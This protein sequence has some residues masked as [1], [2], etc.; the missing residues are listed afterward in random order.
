[1]RYFFGQKN[2]QLNVTI[3]QAWYAHRKVCQFCKQEDPNLID[4]E[5]EKHKCLSCGGVWFVQK[6]TSDDLK[7]FVFLNS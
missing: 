6:P 2:L 4:V 7:K 5:Q 3:E 1:M